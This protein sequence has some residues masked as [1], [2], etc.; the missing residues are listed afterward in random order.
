MA[1]TENN[2][3]KK[4]QNKETEIGDDKSIIILTLYR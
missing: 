4:G 3:Y 2:L 1:T